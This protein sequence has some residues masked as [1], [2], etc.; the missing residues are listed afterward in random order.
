MSAITLAAC[1][2]MHPDYDS[3]EDDDI[4]QNDE[5]INYTDHVKKGETTTVSS[6]WLSGEKRINYSPPRKRPLTRGG[7]EQTDMVTLMRESGDCCGSFP[8]SCLNSKSV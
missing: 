1:S 2:V 7:G 3:G 6:P 5:K 8:G 4:Y